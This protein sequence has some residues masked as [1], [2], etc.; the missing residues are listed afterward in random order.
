[1]KVH[2]GKVSIIRLKTSLH[3]RKILVITLRTKIDAAKC[4]YLI[5]KRN[6]YIFDG[7]GSWILT[8]LYTLGTTDCRLN[9]TLFPALPVRFRPVPEFRV[10]PPP[11]GGQ[12]SNLTGINLQFDTKYVCLRES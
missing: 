9:H 11:P 1:M 2:A 12:V 7:L 6:I 10:K 3:L 8:Y 4:R 5:Q